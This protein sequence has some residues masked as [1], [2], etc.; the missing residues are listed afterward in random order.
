MFNSRKIKKMIDQQELLDAKINSLAYGQKTLSEDFEVHFKR[1]RQTYYATEERVSK[2]I[3]SEVETEMAKMRR[4]YEFIQ[5]RMNEIILFQKNETIVLSTK[6]QL[7]IDQIG[8]LKNQ[9]PKPIEI[10]KNEALWK[11]LEVPMPNW[12]MGNGTHHIESSPIQ[13]KMKFEE[14]FSEIDKAKGQKKRAEIAPIEERKKFAIYINLPEKVL[15][16]LHNRSNEKNISNSCRN[17]FERNGKLVFAPLSNEITKNFVDSKNKK[18]KIYVSKNT[19]IAIHKI[20][21]NLNLSMAQVSNNFVATMDY[22]E[23]T[24]IALQYSLFNSK[25]LTFEKRGVGRPKKIIEKRGVGRP[26]KNN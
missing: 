23:A 20:S 24:E 17:V 5:K 4:Q 11:S 15:N 19:Y 25:E 22:V 1:I 7:L 13:D 6:I 8:D 2:D 3:S 18:L 9:I 10:S 21:K 14:D 26:K 16:Y 12:A